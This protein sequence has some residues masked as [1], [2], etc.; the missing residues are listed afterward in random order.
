MREYAIRRLLLIPPTL[1]VLS[2]LL[3]VV[4][5]VL[6]PMDAAETLVVT[7]EQLAS[8]PEAIERLREFLGLT[9]SLPEQ[10]LR[11]A[12][13]I[14]RGDLGKSLH[15]KRPIRDELKT[16]IPVSMELSLIGLFFTWTISFPLGVLSAVY[17]DKA[18]DYILRGGAYFID[19]IPNFVLGILLITYLAV[20]FRWA[21]PL[22]FVHVWD[23]PIRHMKIMLLPTL[24]VGLNATGNL[25]R[26][27]RTF[28]LEVLRQDY[29][30]TARAKGINERAVLLRHALKNVALPFVTIIGGIIPSLLVSSIIIEQ[31]FNL[32]GMG[33]YLVA[34]ARQLDYNVMMSTTMIFA[35]VTMTAH[36]I[37]DL[38]YA[39]LD[40]RVSYGGSG[41]RR[42]Q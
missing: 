16:R 22:S 36:F 2:I 4:L 27:T 12:G 42:G 30:R 35:I 17:Q 11:W 31:I 29:I 1:I 33:R 6:P 23:D 21:P 24:I 37:T 14:L 18:P 28:L 39:W 40:P 15:T 38:S 41:R 32:P 8:D 13:G 34:A 5:R 26:F 25:I 19:A 9:G 10:Y 20:F 7:D 3:F